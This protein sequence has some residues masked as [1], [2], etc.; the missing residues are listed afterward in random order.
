MKMLKYK[1][2]IDSIGF[3]NTPDVLF[4]NLK[5]H[6]SELAD[7]KLTILSKNL[8]KSINFFL[9][10]PEKKQEEVKPVT[11][12][13]YEPA[14]PEKSHSPAHE[15]EEL[16][17]PEV[18]PFPEVKKK[19][20]KQELKFE[21]ISEKFE[22]GKEVIT[23][24]LFEDDGWIDVTPPPPPPETKIIDLPKK[25]L[26]KSAL[27]PGTNIN[28]AEVNFPKKN[29]GNP[30]TSMKTAGERLG[31]IKYPKPSGWKDK[32][33]Q[34]ITLYCPN[35]DCQDEKEMYYHL[36]RKI[37]RCSGCKVIYQKS[38]LK[39]PEEVKK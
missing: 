13:I 14:G 31:K 7:E 5:I 34:V 37:I 18:K 33:V 27:P 12:R 39:F 9:E 16:K 2:T 3:N 1:S 8:G 4:L 10:L 22:K 35:L 20:K 38:Q 19:T 36:E 28:P 24:N 32:D 17:K 25:D 29:N 6:K 15:L 11:V 30:F 26:S 23:S 21:V